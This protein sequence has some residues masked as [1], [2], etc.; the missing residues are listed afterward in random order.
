MLGDSREGAGEERSY[1]RKEDGRALSA[2]RAA[3]EE[4]ELFALM[5]K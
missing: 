1:G 5:H 4:E 3:R 2:G